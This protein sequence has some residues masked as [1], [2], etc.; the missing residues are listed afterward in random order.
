MTQLEPWPFMRAQHRETSVL[1]SD[2]L[3]SKFTNALHWSYNCSSTRIFETQ[4]DLSA[5]QIKHV[6]DIIYGWN[7]D[8][9]IGLY[10]ILLSASLYFSK[11]GAY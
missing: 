2:N 9:T 11:R 8:G 6:T 10:V 5:N 1:L 7:I 3:I 4:L